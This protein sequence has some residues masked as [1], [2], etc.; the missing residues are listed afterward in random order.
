MRGWLAMLMEKYIGFSREAGV[1]G[2]T[3]DLLYERQ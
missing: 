1:V 2:E 3:I